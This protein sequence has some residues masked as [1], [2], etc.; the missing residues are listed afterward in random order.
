MGSILDQLAKQQTTNKK[1]N[2]KKNETLKMIT[3]V[4]L[5]GLSGLPYKTAPTLVQI[6][7]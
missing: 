6:Q 2:L 1:K 7:N 4:F 3:I 5:S